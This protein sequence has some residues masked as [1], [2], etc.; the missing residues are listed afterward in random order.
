MN[1]D[2]LFE[3]LDDTR[4]FGLMDVEKTEV[5]IFFDVID[6]KDIHEL[7]FAFC[8]LYALG[9]D[10]VVKSFLRTALELNIINKS[11]ICELCNTEALISNPDNQKPIFSFKNLVGAL[12][13][14]VITIPEIEAICNKSLF[15]NERKICDSD[16]DF[17]FHKGEYYRGT[18]VGLKKEFLEY[19]F[20]RSE[21]L[22]PVTQALIAITLLEI[23][24][25]AIVTPAEIRERLDSCFKKDA[26]SHGIHRFI[27]LHYHITKN[28]ETDEDVLIALLVKNIILYASDLHTMKDILSQ[29][30]FVTQEEKSKAKI[31]TELQKQLHSLALTLYDYSDDMSRV[32]DSDT[33]Y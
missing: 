32:F 24:P 15:P 25:D 11:S 7:F 23:Y 13:T 9:G 2:K 33:L 12:G 28:N 14:D 20:E 5:K 1:T 31:R 27:W 18:A 19:C 6:T 10:H 4:Q 21:R 22:D 8:V 30:D 17:L 3:V 26:R 29:F 16:I